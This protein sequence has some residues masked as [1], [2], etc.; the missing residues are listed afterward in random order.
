MDRRA[1]LGRLPAPAWAAAVEDALGRGLRIAPALA[2]RLR[3]LAKGGRALEPALARRMGRRLGADLR[4]VRVHAGPDVDAWTRA[5]GAEAFCLGRGVFLGRA[6]TSGRDHLR[7]VLWHELAHVAAGP[8]PALL[9]FWDGKEHAD[10]TQEACDEFSGELDKLLAHPNVGIERQALVQALRIASSNMDF[11]KR[12][13]H[14][15]ATLRY[16]P[17]M[18]PIIGRWIAGLGVLAKGEGPRHGEAFNYTDENMEVNA[19]R[20]VEEEDAYI[21]AAV[22]ELAEDRVSRSDDGPTLR[23]GR[24]LAIGE[25]EWVKSLAHALHISQDR[26]SHREGTKGYGHDD[27]RC[28]IKYREQLTAAGP[29]AAEPWS[30]DVLMH[31]HSMGCSWERCSAAA[32]QK[33]LNN[34][35][36][37]MERFLRAAGIAPHS[38]EPRRTSCFAAAPPSPQPF[39]PEQAESYLNLFPNPFNKSESGKAAFPRGHGTVAAPL[40]PIFAAHLRRSEP[41]LGRGT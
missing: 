14:A 16:L 12:V 40:A 34:G 35:Y 19:R 11:R 7:G 29:T 41:P 10:L 6:A 1:N 18:I 37:V 8:D 9:R 28:E 21:A 26:G 36:A 13:R 22:K 31:E 25:K 39:D 23:L 27:P 15:G 17:N 24:H 5:F 2:D 30:P 32:Y 3:G 38:P 33:A 20:N 4:G